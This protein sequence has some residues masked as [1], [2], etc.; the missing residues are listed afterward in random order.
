MEAGA[1]HKLINFVL[2]KYRGSLQ[3]D[4]RHLLDQFTLVQVA[5]K[6]VGVGSVGTRSWVLLMDACDGVEP[7]FLQAKEAQPSVLA[8]YLGRSAKFD[9]ASADFAETYPTRTN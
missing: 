1:L 4:R 5:R 9:Q 3:S 8:A 6:V 7:L 2:G